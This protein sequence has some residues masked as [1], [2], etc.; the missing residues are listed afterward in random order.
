ME[1]MAEAKSSAIFCSKIVES[2]ANIKRLLLKFLYLHT[3]DLFVSVHR[4]TDG[5]DSG[6]IEIVPSGSL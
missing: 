3:L 4:A 5:L 6:F 2:I 1:G